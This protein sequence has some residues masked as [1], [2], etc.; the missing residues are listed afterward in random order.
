M[1]ADQEYSWINAITQ[2]IVLQIQSPM[3]PNQLYNKIEIW[4]CYLSSALN[5]SKRLI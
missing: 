2:L 1:R 4:I 5:V 3:E